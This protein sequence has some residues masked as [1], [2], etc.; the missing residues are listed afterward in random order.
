MTGPPAVAEASPTASGLIG[1]PS[2]SL[3]V[4]TTSRSRRTRGPSAS[5]ASSCWLASERSLPVNPLSMSPFMI[6]TAPLVGSRG[7]D[8]ARRDGRVGLGGVD[9]RSSLQEPLG[10]VDDLGG[11]RLLDV[12][13]HVLHQVGRRAGDRAVARVEERRAAPVLL[14]EVGAQLGDGQAVLLQLALVL[15]PRRE[16]C[17]EEH[18]LNARV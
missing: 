9:L 10:E 14:L 12:V 5:R 11:A 15:G 1:L 18:H 3:T 16:P 8:V 7:A 6:S 17:L 4:L 2:R 13:D